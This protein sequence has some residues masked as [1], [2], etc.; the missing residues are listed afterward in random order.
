MEDLTKST[1]RS[2][3][4]IELGSGFCFLLIGN[5][6]Q[7]EIVQIDIQAFP[8]NHIFSADD[9]VSND[10]IKNIKP[11]SVSLS[12]CNQK[13]TLVPESLFEAAAAGKYLSLNC[14]VEK[15]DVVRFQY[16]HASGMVLI[17]ALPEKQLL[18]LSKVF[19]Q[20]IVTHFA[21]H[22][23]QNLPVQKKLH[24]EIHVAFY[25]ELMLLA[26]RNEGRLSF[27]NSF[28][29]RAPEDVI[30]YLLYVA[31][32]CGIRPEEAHLYL[33]GEIEANGK[34]NQAIAKYFLNIHFSTPERALNISNKYTDI[35]PYRFTQ[36]IH[37]FTC[38]L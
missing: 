34:I 15:D 16:L 38:E 26:V 9:L 11:Q 4:S 12:Y 25:P 2:H 31:E 22:F 13:F 7:K 30:Y 8:K 37:Q 29:Y 14:V 27:L 6:E 1:F 20:L 21:G 36:L 28:S 32:Q 24:P 17:Y 3:L 19:P 35:K 5:K 10:N 18:E 33:S 23:L